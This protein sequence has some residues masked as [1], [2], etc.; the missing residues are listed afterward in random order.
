[1]AKLRDAMA[2]STVQNLL[3]PMWGHF[4]GGC[5]INRDALALIAAAGF[6]DV[7]HRTHG[8]QRFTIAPIISGQARR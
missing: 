4:A 8:G 5:H 1:M 6:D 2:K 7:E 3:D